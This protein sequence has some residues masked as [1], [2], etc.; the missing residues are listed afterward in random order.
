MRGEKSAAVVGK[1]PRTD[2]YTC[3]LG[4]M[5]QLREA[6]VHLLKGSECLCIR[7]N[8]HENQ[9]CAISPFFQTEQGL[10]VCLSPGSGGIREACHTLTVQPIDRFGFH[11]V[12]VTPRIGE[13]E[14]QTTSIRETGIGLDMGPPL[15]LWEEMMTPGMEKEMGGKVAVYGNPDEGTGWIR[16]GLNRQNPVGQ[17]RWRTLRKKLNRN[18]GRQQ[19][20]ES[21]GVG[22]IGRNRGSLQIHH[23][24]EPVFSPE[25][26][27]DLEVVGDGEKILHRI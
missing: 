4:L 20:R 2:L 18:P 7:A 22:K 11:P 9:P 13:Q 15:P 6:G 21:T 5:E 24:T 26:K 3:V 25:K 10:D 14:V 17:F 1:N 8:H 19:F 27:S 16:G 12:R 23:H